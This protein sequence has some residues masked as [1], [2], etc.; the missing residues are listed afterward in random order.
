MSRPVPCE[1]HSSSDPGVVGGV[2]GERREW[3][4]MKSQQRA[5]GFR[6]AWLLP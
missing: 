4:E 3:E 1:L 2:R 6:G 5:R